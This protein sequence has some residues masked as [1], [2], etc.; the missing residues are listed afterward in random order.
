MKIYVINK[1][2]QP[3][4]PTT[5]RKARLLLKSGKAKIVKH[6]PFTL[7][8]LY[9][10]SGYVQ[11]AT[12]GIDAGYSHIGFSA[13]NEQAELIGGELT[14]LSGMSERIS[15]KRKYRRTR[16]NRKKY[17]KCRFS[18][19]KVALSWLAPSIQHKLD[20]HHRLINRIKTILPVKQVVIEVASFDI[21]KIQNPEI[22]GKDYQQGEQYGFDNLR[23]YILHR[24]SHKCQ[25]PNCNNKANKATNP[26]L[27]VHHLGFWKNPPDGTN[28]PCN[29]I[30]LCEKCH[31]SKNHKKNGLL[32]G[33]EPKLKAFKGE[34]FM[35]TV[36]WR[37]TQEGATD[38]T[39]G[40][41][42]KAKRRELQLVKSHHNDAFVVAG[43]T[44]Q[45]RCNALVLSQVR[46]HK[47]SLEQFYDARYDDVRDKT[48]KSG[49]QLHSGR[50]V[51]NQNMN[52]ENLRQYRGHK[53]SS[54]KRQIKKK[55]YPYK[56]FDIVLFAGKAYEV[57][58]MQNLGTRLSLKPD[59]DCQTKYKTAAVGKVR[60]L[61]RRGG[62]CE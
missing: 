24:D 27:Q 29:L 36:R 39:Y 40:C 55:R 47:R 52:G 18:N 34:T 21:Q 59:A 46:R 15:E 35:S 2:G 43:G 58:G 16:R 12:L 3:L 25:N 60:S 1:N 57:V 41:I 7:Q 22:E 28:R 50:R 9:G 31:T 5:P 26:I 49:S 32:Y 53:V 6:H 38:A 61:R 45:V 56:Q 54:G 10:S 44:T 11:P 14:M 13:V 51:R 19:R 8:L 62:I 4:M 23:E 20:T 48:V 17:C 42:T 37:L 33:W 30:T